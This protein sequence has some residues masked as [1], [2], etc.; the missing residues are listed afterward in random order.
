MDAD[1]TGAAIMA[2]LATATTA[3]G[4]VI[5]P[6]MVTVRD[7]EIV[8]AMAI[9]AVPPAAMAEAASTATVRAHSTAGVASTATVQADSMV[10]EASMEVAEATVADTA[11]P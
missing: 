3:R 6:E 2:G 11:K 5:G 10:G 7:M 1:I 9:G 4:M 8:Q